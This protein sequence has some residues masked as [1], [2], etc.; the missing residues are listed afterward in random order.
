MVKIKSPICLFLTLSIYLLSCK[1]EEIPSRAVFGDPDAPIVFNLKVLDPKIPS[2]NIKLANYQFGS[3]RLIDNTYIIY[4]PN[5]GFENDVVDLLENGNIIA[6]VVFVSTDVD[7]DC[8][9]HVKSLKIEVKKNSGSVDYPFEYKT[10]NL[11]LPAGKSVSA[12]DVIPIGGALVSTSR[13]SFTPEPDFIGYGEI[14]FELG[15]TDSNFRGEYYESE[16]FVSGLI[17][18]TVTD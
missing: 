8:N 4:E 11:S 9:V 12:F 13:L 16:A 3:I 14:I 2:K 18:I 5:P 6:S 17:M 1:D 7:P 15:R 10:C